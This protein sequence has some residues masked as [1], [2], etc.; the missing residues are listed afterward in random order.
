[1]DTEEKSM[2]YF[3]L[4]VVIV[5]G[6]LLFYPASPVLV[7]VIPVLYAVGL[8]TVRMSLLMKKECGIVSEL[9]DLDKEIECVGNNLNSKNKLIFQVQCNIQ[10]EIFIKENNKEYDCFVIDDMLI[11][12]ASCESIDGPTLIKRKK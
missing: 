11:Q 3:G 8:P 9:V 10:D 7:G 1:M 4:G 6:G 12:D 5:V 2:Y